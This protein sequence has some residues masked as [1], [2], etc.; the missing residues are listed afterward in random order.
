M[1]PVTQSTMRAAEL[2]APGEAEAITLTE[3]AVPK[4][5]PGTTLVSVKAFGLNRSE[6]MT[7]QGL[8]PSVALPRVLGIE[9]VGVVADCPSGAFAPGAAVATCMGGMGR[10]FDGS[11]ADY[12]L[13]PDRQ[14]RSIQPKLPWHALGA[15]P[16]MFQTAWGSLTIGL[17]LKA[18]DRLL[19]RGGTTSVGL[20][21]IAL[22]RRLGASVTATTRHRAKSAAL[23]NAGASAVLIDDG[24][25]VN[26]APVQDAALDLVGT[27]T[28]TDTM[29]TVCRG[30]V[31]MSGMA[32]GG[33][34]LADFAPIAEI[35]NGIW[36]TGY[37]GDVEEFMAMPLQSIIDAIAENDLHLPIGEVFTLD[38]I[39]EAHRALE[40]G[41]T[42]GKTVV[43]T[44]AN[45]L[46][47][48]P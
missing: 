8:S 30:R 16:E 17:D 19:V 6:L 21:A 46:P 7:R 42:P 27:T 28:L 5:E 32:G 23:E 43:V 1:T 10:A 47:G 38:R 2:R 39:V 13:V 3:R 12:V 37:L 44:D 4:A 15:V 25:L 48:T 11:Y 26:R 34:A 35:P 31:C 36:L 24:T 18:N 40:R 41:D 29:K 14:I 20:A 33:W 9:A 22:A 45:D